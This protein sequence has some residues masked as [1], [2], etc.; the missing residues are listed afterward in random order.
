MKYSPKLTTSLTDKA[1]PGS[2]YAYRSHGY[3]WT[4]P[5]FRCLS[6]SGKALLVL[7]DCGEWKLWVPC[8]QLLDDSDVYGEGDE[9]DLTMSDWFCKK[10]GWAE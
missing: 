4:F 9:G 3:G 6:D 5:N 8:S 10:I 7:S 2:R 1:P